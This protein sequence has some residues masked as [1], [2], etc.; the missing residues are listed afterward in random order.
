MKKCLIG[1]LSIIV[2][3][4]VF[5]KSSYANNMVVDGNNE[6]SNVDYSKLTNE[7]LVIEILDGPELLELVVSTGKM[8]DKLMA[9]GLKFKAYAE[10]ITRK[11]FEDIFLNEGLKIINNDKLSSKIN[12][13]EFQ[14]IAFEMIC[15]AYN[16]NIQ[17]Y[18]SIKASQIVYVTTPRG[19]RVQTYYDLDETLLPY[20]RQQVNSELASQYGMTIV[21]QGTSKYNCH[22]YAWYST[23]TTNKHWINYPSPYMTDGSYSRVYSGDGGGTAINYGIYKCDKVYYANNTHSA[24]L[25][26][27]P[28]GE[29]I[30]NQ[31]VYS[32]WGEYGVFKHKIGSV[33]SSYDKSNITIWHKTY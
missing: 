16:E 18:Y 1:M 5:S 8:Q 25:A 17:V 21:S 4:T 29:P 26:N 23:A 24:I 13:F 2:F 7:Q 32:K 11:N 22:S 14:K 10:L 33:L 12:G 31:Y 28:N 3:I 9:F 19:S 30:L 20:K 15:E 27:S 6:N